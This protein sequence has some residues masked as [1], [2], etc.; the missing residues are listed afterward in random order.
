M[1]TGYTVYAAATPL[2]AT[3]ALC[4]LP[5]V[6]AAGAV[7]LFGS[8]DNRT[9]GYARPVSFAPLLQASLSIGGRAIIH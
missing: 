4:T 1:A 2:N 3:H 9:W 7:G 6:D 8:V 5:P